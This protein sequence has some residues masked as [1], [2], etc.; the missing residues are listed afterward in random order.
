MTFSTNAPARTLRGI[1][2]DAGVIYDGDFDSRP[3]WEADAVRADL[4]AIR[5][6]LGC[7]AVLV[8]A[9]DIDRLLETA[10]IACEEGLAV[11]IQPRLFDARCGEIAW[12][13]AEVATRAEELRRAVDRHHREDRPVHIVEFGTCAYAGAADNSSQASDVLREV[14]GGLE[15]PETLVRD[16]QGQA[17]YLDEMFD[18]FDQVGVDGTFV[19]GFSE[20]R[21]TRSDE[22]RQDLDRASYGIVAPLPEGTWQPKAAFGAVARRHGAAP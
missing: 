21:L 8:M 20:P 9:T 18:I 22:P 13:L 10:R 15:V 11:W 7:D 14:D 17:D 5:R 6:R 3:V 2:Y 19:W 4:R 1:G 16:E 12:H